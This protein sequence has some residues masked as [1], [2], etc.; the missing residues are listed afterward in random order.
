ML[1]DRVGV[2]SARP[3]RF[4]ETCRHRLAAGAGQHDR[5][6]DAMPSAR[7][8]AASGRGCARNRCGRSATSGAGMTSARRGSAL[9]SSS[10]RSAALEVLV[11]HRRDPEL[12]GH[13][14][15]RHGRGT[16]R[17]PAIR[18]F[19][20]DIVTTLRNVG[21]RH[22]RRDAGRHCLRPRCCRACRAVRRIFDPL[23]AAYYA[24]PM[25][26]FY[27][28]LIVILGLGD[29]PQIAIGFL[30]A[31][32]AVILNTLNGLD[33]VP[34]VLLKTARVHR[35]GA[36]TDCVAGTPAVRRALRLYRLQARGRVL[37]HRR[38]RRRVHHLEP[39]H[40]LRDRLR[41]Q[42]L[43]QPRDVPDDPAGAGRGDRREHV[44]AS[45]G[46]APA[47]AAR[48]RSA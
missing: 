32:V 40:R 37:V 7:S 44:A 48:R 12:H 22:R 46:A 20:S 43:R 10:S 4:L 21:G 27:P 23:F 16:R 11:P 18:K 38:D 19:T 35:L 34:R 36:L 17:D 47:G 41:L 24:I 25:Y 31:V 5:G 9:R 45:V 39:R 14:A 6:L 42:Q 33:R 1:A 29:L 15:V 3:G 26:A 8:P 30:L 28:L 13:P 2:M